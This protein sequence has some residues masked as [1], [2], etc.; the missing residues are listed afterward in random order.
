M[1]IGTLQGLRCLNINT[2]IVSDT[3]PEFKTIQIDDLQIRKDTMYL[4]T[5]GYGII[6][7]AKIFAWQ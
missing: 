5:K 1:I 4:A 2:G 7:L 3:L 6:I